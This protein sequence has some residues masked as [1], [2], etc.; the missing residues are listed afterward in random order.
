MAVG[1]AV[2]VT[3]GGYYTVNSITNGAA[4]VLTNLGYSGNAAASSSISSA[5]A[6]VPAGVVGATGVQGATGPIGATGPTSATV[7]AK[8]ADQVVTNST[9]LVNDSNLAVSVAANTTYGFQAM[10]ICAAAANNATGCQVAFTAPTGSTISWAAIAAAEGATA[11]QVPV[12]VT[13]NGGSVNIT[14][15]QATYQ[16]RIQGTLVTS[17]TSGTLQ[18]QFANGGAGAGRTTTMKAGST[19]SVLRSG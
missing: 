2:F 15:A 4:V 10:L 14:G 19:I 13:T 6:V 18:L 1:Q 16:I 17:S 8:S 5:A 9:T 3:G 7:V 11:V 12:S